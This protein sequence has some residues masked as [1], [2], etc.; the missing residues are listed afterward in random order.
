MCDFLAIVAI[1]LS[2]FASLLDLSKHMAG[3][4]G[5]R[6]KPRRRASKRRN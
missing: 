2:I 6:R 1:V 3:L 5:G 4:L